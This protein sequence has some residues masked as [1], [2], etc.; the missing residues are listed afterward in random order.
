[1]TEERL[2]VLK[3]LSWNIGMFVMA[4][5]LLI[6]GCL[7]GSRLIRD[8]QA[9]TDSLKIIVAVEAL[10]TFLL[11]AAYNRISAETIGVLF[12]AIIGFALGKIS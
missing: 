2:K 8:G 3:D 7:L 9:I 5:A 11:I 1:M 4:L 6:V 10:P 12:G